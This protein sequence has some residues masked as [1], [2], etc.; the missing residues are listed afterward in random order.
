[1]VWERCCGFQR[2]HLTF[3]LPLCLLRLYVL[4]LTVL[5]VV[6]GG[7]GRGRGRGRG[8]VVVVVVRL[9]RPRKQSTVLEVTGTA[10]NEEAVASN[11]EVLTQVRACG[12]V[13]V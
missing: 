13:C 6:G 1:M 2:I 11:P 8:H 9:S 4:D 3:R 7:R 5:V 10:I 12:L